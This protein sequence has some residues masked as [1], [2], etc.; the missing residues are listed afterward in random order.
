M[1]AADGSSGG[2]VV[3]G[4]VGAEV[5]DV[6]EVVVLDGTV[7]LVDGA[8]VV[9]GDVT[10]VAVTSAETPPE[11]QPAATTTASDRAISRR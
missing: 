10:V 1:S 9:T 2:V 8:A 5:V 6:A 11:A 7:V 3:E 4:V